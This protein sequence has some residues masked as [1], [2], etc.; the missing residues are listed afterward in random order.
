MRS[1]RLNHLDALRAA[2]ML[3]VV[4][5]HVT[6]NWPGYVTLEDSTIEALEWALAA[7]RWS[8]ALFFLMAGFFGAQLL[9]RWGTARFAKDRLRRIGIPLAFGI[10]V[11]VPLAEPILHA[12][13]PKLGAPEVPAHLWFLWD[14]L[15]LY[16]VAVVLLRAP[17]LDR[18]GAA[19]ARL[20]A[21]PLAVPLLAVAT[22]ALLFGGQL[23][24]V[25]DASWLVP[26]PELMAFY[27]SFF[28]VGV[29]LHGTPDGVDAGGGRPWLTGAIA[30][31]AL[32]PL[33]LLDPR[34][35]WRGNV[36]LNPDEGRGWLLLLCVFTWAAVLCLVGVG[37]RLLAAERPAVRYVADASYWIFLMHLPLVPLAIAIAVSLGQPFPVAWA[38]GM[39]L[40]FS[41]LLV[42][43]ELFVRHTFVGRIL[44]GPRPPRRWGLTGRRPAVALPARR[45]RPL[46]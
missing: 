24:S 35:V 7:T 41:F 21:S 13:R 23:I 38:V 45:A 31:A 16:G 6:L 12:V 2:A 25:G 3:V 27:G 40:L 11:I 32:V 28:V 19:T 22:A 43:Y 44:N 18:A 36:L 33:V 15:F 34:S 5:W 46:D 30:L 42:T 26:K 37:R 8:L 1:R 17:W 20:V 39:A 10:L 14:V 4:V 29:L 9:R